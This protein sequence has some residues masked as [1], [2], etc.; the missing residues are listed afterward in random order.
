[1]L[2]TDARKVSFNNT[3]LLIYFIFTTFSGA[4]RK[5][6]VVSES[7]NSLILLVQLGAPIIVFV[8]LR[9]IPNK[10]T[11]S[12]FTVFYGIV[13]LMMALNPL[14]E[15]LMH[16]LL[17]F[18]LHFGFWLLIILYINNREAFQIEKLSKPF[19]IVCVVELALA[20]VQFTLPPTH[21]INRYSSTADLEVIAMLG[22]YVR[23]SG[24][25]SYISGFG[26][27]LFFAGCFVWGTF[28]GDSLSNTGKYIAVL[29][30]LV[31]TLMNGSRSVM[32]A[33]LMLLV[34]AAITMQ[35]KQ[36]IVIVMVSVLVIIIGALYGLES[37]IPFIKDAYEGFYNRT[38]SLNANGEYRNR[39]WGPYEE[40]MNFRG[41]Y[42]LFGVG[43]GATYQ[44][45][46]QKWGKSQAVREYGYFEE[47]PERIVIEGGFFLFV[48]RFIL[49][50]YLLYNLKIPALYQI[51]IYIILLFYMP[52]IFNVFMA[53]YAYFG[54]M[55]LDKM[56]CLKKAKEVKNAFLEVP[57]HSYSSP[58]LT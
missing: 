11:Q 18:L 48:L 1:M 54:L 2:H 6:V 47:E 8:L 27:F 33:V 15:T 12:F 32:A 30:T 43:L 34:F 51:S 5:W 55:Y 56:Y 9:G 57:E 38:T 24:S 50:G 35:I 49:F 21:F 13:L 10:A 58:S 29:L 16:G 52:M 4:L 7:V 26:C 20:M 45:A 42:P 41:N 25:F 31:A 14:N 37:K 46:T 53:A 17:G 23:V 40:V 44:G 28:M 3:L 39:V 22:D 36:K 19:F